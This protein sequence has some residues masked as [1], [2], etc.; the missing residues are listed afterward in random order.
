[1]RVGGVR[2]LRCD[3]LVTT[4]ALFGP[5][6]RLVGMRVVAGIAGAS[7]EGGVQDAIMCGL[8]A[9]VARGLSGSAPEQTWCLR[10]MRCVALKAGL[11]LRAG[12]RAERER[13]IVAGGAERGTRAKNRVSVSASIGRVTLLT[14]I[15][16]CWGMHHR[17][18]CQRG[19][20]A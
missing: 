6:R 4:A 8:V 17:G 15:G 14:R 18:R 11:I 9:T 13:L 5:G 16:C 10:G 3:L 2:R 19:V 7:R 20:A 12:V 1:M